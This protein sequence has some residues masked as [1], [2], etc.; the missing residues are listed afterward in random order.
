MKYITDEDYAT[1]EKNGIKKA[2][3]RA[4]V[5]DF[6]WEIEKAITT[7]PRNFIN[8]PPQI[9]R[10]LKKNK[11]SIATYRGRINTGWSIERAMTEKVGKPGPR[12]K[13]KSI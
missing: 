5:M 4:R 1:A 12:P 2:T 11:I 7:P 9:L 13:K 8:I 3:V 6:D 10:V